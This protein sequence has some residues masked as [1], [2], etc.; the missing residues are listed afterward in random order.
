MKRKIKVG[1]FVDGDFIPSYDG[2]SN[3]FH[4]LS[5]HLAM[6]G[7]EVVIF[8]G[9]RKW[10]DVSL[11]KKEPFKTYVF[12]IENYY[13]NL[14][15]IASIIQ[16]ESIDIIQ[17]DNLE[18]ILLQGV[19]LA[20]LTGTRLVSEMHYVVRNLAKKLGA[21]KLRIKEIEK[22]EKEV[23]RSIDH[24]ISLSNEDK[25]FIE[26]YMDIPSERMSVIPSGVDLKEL[27]Y[28]GPNFKEKNI[29][30][31]GN[32]YFKPN[33]DAVRIIKDQIYPKLK[34]QGFRFTIAGDCPP[35]LKKDCSAPGFSFVGTTPDLN[36]LFKDATL[37]LAPID[38][39]TGMRI[40]LLNY[41]AAGTPIL[42]T[43]IATNGF[44]RKDCFVVEDDY[45]KYAEK[46]TKLLENKKGLIKL[47]AKGYSMVKKNYDWDKIAK[48]TI[49]IYEKILAVPKVKR[50]AL[51]KDV[52]KNKEPVW[53]QEAVAKSR[54]KKIKSDELPNKF[55]FVVLNGNR[56]K[57][58]TYHV[59]KIIALEGMPGAGKTTFTEKYLDLNKRVF[60]PQLHIK[61]KKILLKNN[62]D[63]SKEFLMA[64]R[65]KT[66]LIGKLGKNYPEIV[67]DRTFIT[68]LAYCYARSKINNTPEEYIRL[69]DFYEKIKNEITFP[70]H[71][72]YMD[73]SIKKS[74]ERRSIHSGK[75]KYQNWFN[76]L[77]LKHFRNF[78][79]TELEK[80]LPIKP[81][82]VDTSDLISEG[83]GEKINKI[84][85][86]L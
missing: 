66:R 20:E 15:L 60:V 86:S 80:I 10:S 14:E 36:R 76:P 69:I 26:K 67:V 42:T 48:Q 40:K 7:I 74:L 25:P 28:V 2:A 35:S 31:L 32:L 30:F 53:L 84:I 75:E 50:N 21:D 62:L 19:R 79:K 39:G 47:S 64:E 83:T 45:S 63:T 4:Y 73:V 41:L 37:A 54:F 34:K 59:D 71:I 78:Y 77:F 23:G 44:D 56:G 17:F 85:N 58:E 3:R 18:P 33:E 51:S 11:I 24:L 8:H 82:P 16:K 9:Y 55:S 65:N 52:L 12:P 49:N 68:T 43:G 13:N 81:I 46:I 22:I 29:I 61:D 38:E 70:T 27:K 72:I 5:R 1:I 57:M 6:N